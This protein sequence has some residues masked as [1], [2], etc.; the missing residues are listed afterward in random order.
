MSLFFIHSLSVFR[1]G[2]EANTPFDIVI[3]NIVVVISKD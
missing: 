1:L 2:N 3:I